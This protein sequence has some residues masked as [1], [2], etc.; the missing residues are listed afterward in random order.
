MRQQGNRVLRIGTQALEGEEKERPIFFDREPDGP[1]ELLPAQGI[2]DGL[3]L[4]VER[5][6]VT[7]N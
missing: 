2:F 5:E 6:S 4:C 1:P 7:G 3:A